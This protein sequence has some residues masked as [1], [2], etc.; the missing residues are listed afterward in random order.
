VT[1]QKN[2]YALKD[3][4]DKSPHLFH[5]TPGDVTGA[6]SAA[7]SEQEA[8]KVLSPLYCLFLYSLCIVQA[9]QSSVAQLLGLLGRTIEAISFV[10]L[11]IDHRLGD[12][13]AEYVLLYTIANIHL[14]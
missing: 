11:L 8:W 13:I 6:R 3:L 5:S 7:V 10:L 4:L 9:E 1:V 12:L 14:C 2:L